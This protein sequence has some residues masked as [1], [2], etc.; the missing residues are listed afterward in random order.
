MRRVLVLVGLLAVALPVAA[1]V[2][3]V[4]QVDDGLYRFL[5][6]QQLQGRLPG[7][8]LTHQPL[9]AG[10]AQ[11]Y[12]DSLLVH[13]AR[14]SRVD[15]QLLD[16]YRRTETGPGADW[17]NR[18]FARLY[19][20]GH[21]LIGASDD[22][23][24]VSVNPIF[25]GSWG[26]GRR[27]AGKGADDAPAV[28]QNTR[29]TH[30]AGSIGPWFFFEGRFT[31]NS[32]RVVEG[33]SQDGSVP[34]R[35]FAKLEDGVYNWMDAVG[36]V[37]ARGKYLEARFGR[38]RLRWGHAL[39]SP[40]LSNYAPAFDHVL[41]KARFWRLE[42]VSLFS[43]YS[44]SRAPGFVRGDQVRRRK[45]GSTHR[46][47]VHLPGRLEVS[48]FETVV[49]ATDSLEVRERFDLSYANPVIFLR[50]VERDRGSPD[51]V[52]LGASA[53]WTP[54]R[55]ARVFVELLLDEFKADAVGKEWWANKWVWN[56]GLHA[57][58][59]DG[60][61]ARMEVARLRPFMYSHDDEIDAFV[62]FGDLLGHPAGPNAWDYTLALDWQVSPR[63]R[64]ASTTAVTRRGRNDGAINY[65][66]DPLID[67]EAGR[68]DDFGHAILQG[69]RQRQILSESLVSFELLPTLFAE[70]ALRYQ[71]LDDAETGLDRWVTPFLQLQWGMPFPSERW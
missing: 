58:P 16:R 43:G 59:V 34:R 6:R 10:D 23:W 66:S 54:V 48:I 26:L 18:R 3:G 61:T 25:V 2:D 37:G 9:S 42:Y 63:L 47:A 21:D 5:F 7:A 51:N 50:A 41:L 67:Y 28:W 33:I 65:G 12:L 17:V 8:H 19:S 15:Q 55:G 68:D 35:G 22:D 13:R 64:L 39:A 52:L 44:S 31:E 29:G 56:W 32:Q 70:A 46:L 53:A 71:S 1:Q 27:T 24:S 69:I 14:L 62:H 60:L 4:L 45:Y 30:I 11:G 36:V 38:D 57:A 20:N 49:F 40:Y